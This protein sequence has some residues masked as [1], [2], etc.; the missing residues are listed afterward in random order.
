MNFKETILPVLLIIVAVLALVA[1]LSGIAV[2]NFS[3][4]CVTQGGTMSN[5]GTTLWCNY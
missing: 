3:N 2:W 1:A 4:D 5:Q